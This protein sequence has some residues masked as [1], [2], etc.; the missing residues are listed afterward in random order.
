MKC[1]SRLGRP[2]KLDQQRILEQGGEFI[3][4]EF[5]LRHLRRPV[6]AQFEPYYKRML[7]GNLSGIF[8]YVDRNAARKDLDPSFYEFLGRLVTIRFYPPADLVLSNIEG[9]GNIGSPTKKQTDT[10]WY[11]LL[12]PHAEQ[13]KKWVRQY[14]RS[15][16]DG[17]NRKQAWV[18]YAE[19]T[20]KDDWERASKWDVSDMPGPPVACD[21]ERHRV[22]HYDGE[23][24]LFRQHYM[25]LRLV[26]KELFWLLTERWGTAK[27]PSWAVRKYLSQCDSW[28]NAELRSVRKKSH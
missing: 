13:A 23:R 19:E 8:D 3:A 4:K 2:S 22:I 25:S 9:R 14:I 12:L 28:I 27:R 5:R 11:K 7:G 17:W 26:P 18:K 16:T 24:P 15:H 21:L 10:Y 1:N 6:D 20:C